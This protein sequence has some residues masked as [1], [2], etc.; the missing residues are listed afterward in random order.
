MPRHILKD[1]PDV[2]WYV[3]WSTIVDAPVFAGTRAEFETEYGRSESAASE[4]FDRA[5]ATGTSFIGGEGGWYDDTIIVANL[6]E[7]GPEAGE[8]ARTSLRAFVE[9]LDEGRNVDALALV[10][11]FEPEDVEP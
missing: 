7:G 5:D 8:I 4:R 11:P 10:I 1:R 9:A 6:P 3:M 2:D